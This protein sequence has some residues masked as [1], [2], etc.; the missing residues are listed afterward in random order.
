MVLMSGSKMARYQGTL[1]NRENCG[2][3]KKT[4]LGRVTGILSLRHIVARTLDTTP[5][6]CDYSLGPRQ[7]TRLR[8]IH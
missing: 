5:V 1:V 7:V 3:N 4:G 6:R 8:M 2:G